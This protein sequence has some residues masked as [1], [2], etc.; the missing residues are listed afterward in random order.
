MYVEVD[1]ELSRNPENCCFCK[2]FE[3]DEHI[4]ESKEFF[5]VANDYPYM[6]DHIMLLPKRHVHSQLDFTPEEL[7][8]YHD[9]N[10]KVVEAYY[11]VF[12]GCFV[13]TREN[14]P[15]QTQWHWHRHFT[16]HEMTI[17]P[18]APRVPFQPID[19]TLIE[20]L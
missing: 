17:I 16:P 12:G 7:A 15:K 20:L 9:I 3:K 18:K 13:F 11:K 8:D 14:T 19:K 4:G 2:H 5:I 10:K 6:P 1:K